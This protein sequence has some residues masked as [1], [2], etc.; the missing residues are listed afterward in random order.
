MKPRASRWVVLLALL[1]AGCGGPVRTD[2]STEGGSD[3][4]GVDSTLDTPTSDVSIDTP[5]DTRGQC[6]MDV[7]CTDGVF[8]NGVE[9]CMPGAPGASARGCLPASPP[10]ACM[11]SQT[12]N[13]SMQRCESAC[14]TAADADGDGHR[15]QMCGGNDCD[16]ADAN[17][18]PGNP[19]VC[20]TTAHDEDCDPSTFGFRD[21]DGDSYADS[22]CCNVDAATMRICGDDCNDSRPNVHPSLAEVCDGLDNNCDGMI[23]EGSIQTFYRDM[24]NDGYGTTDTTMSMPGCTP[25]TGY[26]V[27]HTDCNDANQMINPATPEICDVGAVDE[28]C[29]GIVNPPA[30]CMCLGTASRMCSLPGAC[31]AGT[32]RCASGSWGVCSIAPVAESCNGVDDNCNGQTDEGVLIS[33]YA[34]TDN[35]GYPAAGATAMQVCPS[36]G[37]EFVGGCPANLTNRVP[38]GA[39]VID[40]NDADSNVSP[41]SIEICDASMV[42][43]NCDG[44]ANPSTLC[45]CSGSVTRPCPLPGACA[46][47][48]QTC[49]SGAWNSCSISPITES[50]NTVDDNCDGVVDEG[51]TVTCYADDDNDT[52]AIAGA[53]PAQACPVTGRASVGGCPTNQTNRAP[54]VGAIDC[55]PTDPAVNPGAIELCDGPMLDENCSGVANEGCSCT[56]GAMR[57]CPQP[58]ACAAGQQSCV[59]GAW[60]TCSITPVPEACN[61]I[62]DNCDGAVDEGLSS[63][64]YADSDDDTFA[65][66]GASSQ[67]CSDAS[68]T[69]VGGCPSGYT[70]RNPAPGASDCDDF[71]NVRNPLAAETCNGIDDD[72]DG[73]IDETLLVTC[74]ADTDGDTYAAAGAPGTTHCPDANR[75]VVGGCPVGLTNR[76]PTAGN[77]DC[78]DSAAGVNPSIV[79]TCNNV[80]DNC[81]GTIDET[82]R[83]T[84]YPDTD[85]D[86]YAPTSASV[87]YCPVAGRESVGGCP[88]GFTNRVPTAGATDCNDA[89]QLINPAATELCDALLV[90]ENCDGTA[91]PA[92]LCSCSGSSTRS[93]PEP[94]ACSAGLQTCSGGAWGNCSISPTTEIC[95]NVDNNCDGVV[96]EGVRVVCYLDAD[97]DGYPLAGTPAMPSVCPVAGR[98]AAGGCPVNTTFRQPVAP[99]IDCQD[100]NPAVH[101]TV[102]DI[103]NNVDDDCNGVVDDAASANLQCATPAPAAPPLL[104][105]TGCRAGGC[106]VIACYNGR[107]DCNGDPSDGCEVDLNTVSNCG[108]CGIACGVGGTCDNQRCT[109]VYGVTTSGEHACAWREGGQVAC[110]GTNTSGELGNGT[111]VSSPTAVAVAGL[112]YAVEVG[113]GNGFTCAR[114]SGRFG[115]PVYCWGAGGFGRLGNGTT[116]SSLVPVAVTGV[117]TA[118]QLSVGSY[119]ACARLYDSTV[120]CWGQGGYGQIGDGGTTNRPTAVA[121]PGITTA[122]EVSAGGKH[123]CVRIAGGGV[124]CWGTNANGQI[125]DGTLTMRLL[126]VAVAGLTASQ[127]AAG[128]E[129]TCART[130]AGGIACWGSNYFGQLGDNTTTN[131]LTPTA[132]SMAFSTPTDIAAAASHTCASDVDPTYGYSRTYCWGNNLSGQLG[133]G[134]LTQR[135]T[136]VRIASS[137]DTVN[138]TSS[139]NA[140]S[141]CSRRLTD[142]IH[143]WG[144]NNNGASGGGSVGGTISTPTTVVNLLPPTVME[145]GAGAGGMSCARL[146]NGRVVCWGTNTNGQLGNGGTAMRAFPGLVGGLVDAVQLSVGGDYVCA[147]RSNGQVAC[148]GRNSE[149]QLGNSTN[150]DA[151]LPTTV[152]GLSGAVQV[153]TGTHSTCAR[154]STG[155]IVCWGTGGTGEFG[156]GMASGLR[157]APGASV[158]GITTAV[159]LG[160]GYYHGCARLQDGSVRCWG[161][162]SQGQIGVG[163]TGSTVFAPTAISGL[164]DALEFEAGDY[165][166]CVRRASGGG[167]VGCWGAGLSGQI[168]DNT[169][170]NR[171]SLTAVSGLS[172]ANEISARGSTACARVLDRLWCWGLNSFGQIGD[173]S[174]SNRLAPV[175]LGGTGFASVG[176]GTY[177]TCATR[178]TTASPLPVGAAC[179]GHNL[180]G[181]VGT[182][183]TSPPLLTPTTVRALP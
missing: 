11:A 7:D 80:D 126:P 85:A 83:V 46:S 22:R 141:T 104:A 18:F 2:G 143:C 111:T 148:W 160:M 4:L 16:D 98:A 23:D 132:V 47:G 28:N 50:C 61:G 125:G 172:G 182:G 52:Y 120:R 106:R 124:R 81:N 1:V 161:Y 178:R 96:D 116:T 84:C 152:T 155:D 8:C 76:A 140:F 128:F 27:S 105:Y 89:N 176:G 53:L 181:A 127:I 51:L 29:D 86:S 173:N 57:S 78:A 58:G 102:V 38:V 164:N 108:G 154:R 69:A 12:C 39:T 70:N 119:H 101:P 134:T 109:G 157:L 123:T 159:D 94:G 79:E 122:A 174:T 131:R 41:A 177:D 145:T 5:V 31:A 165:F 60:G 26:V 56:A 43:E 180:G 171:P 77:I 9:R 93:C 72:C 75:P 129:H 179:W 110:W 82:L 170:M 73:M 95:D 167:S 92:G 162:N 183:T 25:P 133:D 147:T 14:G 20:D 13:E 153:E 24:D 36:A 63:T 17:R 149:G 158:N 175:L 30:D 168:G 64:C 45:V 112:G 65:P 137:A 67:Q 151:T 48:M 156:D 49:T 115:G 19:E 121:V 88:S 99:N 87:T 71:S 150:V 138:I 107:G 103:C 66:P 163:T 136:P 139:A 33:C 100:G 34:D 21:G 118:T 6:V 74:Y 35:D 42:D 130:T 44:V 90:D 10:T 91:N 142:Q 59:S 97:D 55:A 62:D 40:C 135:L 146:P 32:E 114:I 3:G 15:A 144:G 113:A 117:T 37:R 169:G 68:R 54:A 166:S